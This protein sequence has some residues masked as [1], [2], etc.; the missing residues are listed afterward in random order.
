MNCKNCKSELNDNDNFCN[1]CGAKVIRERI[2]VKSLFSHLLISLGWDSNF[3]ITLRFLLS[4]PQTIIRE[5]INGTRKKY[6]NPFTFFAIS[7]A[8]SLFVFNQY[9]E[10]FILMSTTT[11]I[12][13]TNELENVS[14]SITNNNKKGLEILGYKNQA[15]LNKSI[16]EFQLKYY[17][18]ISFIYLPLFTL[19]AFLVFRKPY[20]YGEHLVI[21]TYFLGI[22]TFFGVLTFIFSLI[23]KYNILLYATIFTFIY[24]SYAYKKIYELSFGKLLMKILKFIGILLL[25]IIIGGIITFL[26][27]IAIVIIKSKL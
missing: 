15:E 13:Q 2:T 25:V 20:N 27:G 19:I 7:L 10:Q 1:E 21:N 5:Y 8:V 16:A 9:S 18:L 14:A 3:F 6:T 22:T 17:N 26:I 23:T 24:Y 4:K 11:N 12:Q